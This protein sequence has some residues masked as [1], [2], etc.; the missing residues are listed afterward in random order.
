M[1]VI[2]PRS[3]KGS[4]R[5]GQSLSQTSKDLQDFDAKRETGRSCLREL[6]GP[7]DASS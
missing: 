2:P 1:L 6:A 4:K 3:R 7:E 5:K